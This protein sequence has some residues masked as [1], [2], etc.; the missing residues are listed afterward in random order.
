MSFHK[1]FSPHLAAS[2]ENSVIETQTI[3]VPHTQNLII[4]S[5][6]GILTPIRSHLF[7]ADWIKALGIPVIVVARSTLG[8]INHTCLTLEALRTRKI[9]ILGVIPKRDTQYRETALLL[10]L[11]T[12][13]CTGRISEFDSHQVQKTLGQIPLPVS[14]RSCLHPC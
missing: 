13:S 4:E 2:L 3:Q 10:R 14:L 8:T 12:G 5:A 9:P 6:G 11:W 7:F 1:P